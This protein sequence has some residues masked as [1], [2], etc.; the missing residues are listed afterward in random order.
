MS[1]KR[2]QSLGYLK[3]DESRE[4]S[5]YDFFTQS[6]CFCPVMSQLPRGAEP[7]YSTTTGYP[8]NEAYINIM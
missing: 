7:Y 8:G 3:V 2:I 1:L 6:Q 4:I 5:M